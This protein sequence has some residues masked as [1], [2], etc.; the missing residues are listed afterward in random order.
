MSGVPPIEALP[1]PSRVPLSFAQQRLW[2]LSRL[3]GSRDFWYIQMGLRLRGELNEAA[4]HSALNGLVARHDVLRTTFGVEDGEPFQRIGPAHVCLP[5]KRDNLTAAADVETTLADLTRHEAQAAFNLEVREGLADRLS[6]LPVQYA[7]YALWQRRWLA[8]EVFVRR[9]EYWLRTLAGAPAALKL[10]ANRP[11]TARRDYSGS[12]I[13][14]VLSEPLTTRLKTLSRRHG[15]T[16]FV[17]LLAG[18]A[19]VLAR[20]S[21]QD[22]LVI[23][24]L[25]ANRTRSESA[26]LIGLFINTP[27]LRI[28]LSGDPPLATLLERVNAVALGAQANQDL[29]FEQVVELVNPPIAHTPIVHVILASQNNEVES[30]DLPGL[31]VERVGIDDRVTQHDLAEVGE[32]IR[33]RLIYATSQFERSTV[34]RFVGYLQQ[35]LSQMAGDPEQRALSAPLQLVAERRRLLAASKRTEAVGSEDWCTHELIEAGVDLEPEPMRVV[36]DDQSLSCR[37]LNARATSAAPRVSPP[38]SPRISS[39]SRPRSVI[40]NFIEGTR[41]VTEDE[42]QEKSITHYR[43]T[44]FYREQIASR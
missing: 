43:I 14:F 19:L 42:L 44:K 11:R 24:M 37:E 25:S 20:L 26:G 32:A 18:C 15:T 35:A 6:P 23:G 41:I 28:N 31:E 17:T 34:E 16:L 29:P 27:A 40:T 5:L 4:L 13:E 12:C 36:C 21:G 8:G 9:S 33:G 1:R 38:Q 22:E 3:E 10:Q 30:A 39:H 7:D 2:L